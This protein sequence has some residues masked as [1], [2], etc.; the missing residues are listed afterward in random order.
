MHN[1]FTYG[2]LMFAEV[3]QRVVS[4][5]YEK[6]N[7]TLLGYDRKTVKDEVYPALVKGKPDSSVAGI[8]YQ[9][10]SLKDLLSLDEF[11]GEYYRRETGRLVLPENVMIT[12]VFYLVKP[13][14][15]HILSERK[16]DPE[17]FK[18]T[19]I[20]TFLDHYFGFR[21]ITKRD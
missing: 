3:W 1:V 11:E 7:A 13:E 14:F 10:V 8:V 6:T 15:H 20:H 19:G 9:G 21:K 17:Y 4:G 5:N 18:H 16:W 12:T 2:T